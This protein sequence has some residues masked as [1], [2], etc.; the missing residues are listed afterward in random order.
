MVKLLPLSMAEN[1][2][3]AVKCKKEQ[4]GR[5]YTEEIEETTVV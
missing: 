1:R 5:N 3:W 4:T 2:P